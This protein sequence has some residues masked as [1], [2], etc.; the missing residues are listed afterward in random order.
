MLEDEAMTVFR[1]Q[2]AACRLLLAAAIVILP[3]SLLAC[4]DKNEDINLAVFTAADFIGEPR[5]GPAPLKVQFTD[6]SVSAL[7]VDSWLWDFGD[8]QTSTEQ[9]PQHLYTEIGVHVIT[10][11]ISGGFGTRTET[12]NYITT[13]PLYVNLRAE[14]TTKTMPDSRA[15]PMWGYAQDSAFGAQDG[16]VSVPGP[17]LKIPT[18]TR[19]LILN[20]DN[21]LPVPTSIVISGQTVAASPVRLPNG[22]VRSFTHETP[23]DNTIPVEYVWDD[24]TP[25]TCLY[26]SGTHP[27]VQV[28]MGLYGAL[29]QDSD[30]STA[31]G[32]YTYD[33]EL[34]LLYSEIDPSLHDAVDADDYGT[35]KLITS[36]IDYRPEYFLING[37][38]YSQPGVPLAAGSEGQRCLIRFLNA[39]LLTH[40]P[41]LNG[42]HME[43]IA[44]DGHA[45]N[46]PRHC[47]SLML[48]A[49]KTRDAI[50]TLGKPGTYSL[51]DRRLYLRNGAE[52]PGGMLVHLE[53]TQ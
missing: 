16:A 22:R 32:G 37:E 18:G 17:L 33:N 25:G 8:G 19:R 15:V 5:N 20:L 48:H 45:Y 29:M 47:Y 12:K 10:L 34:T 13:T 27:A 28:Q 53:V 1:R 3:L 23:P 52:S 11:T 7:P 9:N 38:P 43:V 2:G 21:N 30:V 24:P 6:L 4:R 39:G 44:E 40:A 46:Y 26:M 41:L 31:Y 51:F 50:I 42:M 35:G 49:G 36:T 14:A